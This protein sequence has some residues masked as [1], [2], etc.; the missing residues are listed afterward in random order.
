MNLRAY[1]SQ[2]LV[3]L[4][5]DQF[6]VSDK[7]ECKCQEWTKQCDQNVRV[8]WVRLSLSRHVFEGNVNDLASFAKELGCAG[9]MFA[10]SVIYR[11]VAV[12]ALFSKGDDNSTS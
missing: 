2:V 5:H 12:E 4:V 1:F 9:K 10:R 11:L 7:N 6:S 8:V 3:P